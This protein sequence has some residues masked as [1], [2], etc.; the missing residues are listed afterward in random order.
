MDALPA[1]N[2]L[3]QFRLWMTCDCRLRK[4][5]TS[6]RACRLDQ[7]AAAGLNA[8]PPA[9]R[10]ELYGAAVITFTASGPR[11]SVSGLAVY[12]DNWAVIELAKHDLT[13][14][15]R[16]VDAVCTGDVDLLF[17]VTNAA[18]LIGPQGESRDAVRAFLDKIGPHWFP[19]LLSAIDAIARETQGDAPAKSCVADKFFLSYWAHRVRGYTP[20]SGKIIDMSEIFRLGAMLDWLGPQR[21]SIREGSAELGDALANMIRRHRADSEANPRWLDQHFPRLQF[22]P[23]KPAMFTYVNLV[24]TLITEAKSHQL[25]SH[26]GMDFCHAVI[27]SAFASFATLDTEWKRRIQTLPPHRLAFV[28]DPSQL[29]Q[30]VTDIELTL[31]RRGSLS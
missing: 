4:V 3:L 31:K 13:R 25:N 7:R 10:L 8:L 27:G 17:S 2:L 16:F 19:V 6:V 28:Y 14:R 12:L 23:S 22:N 15:Q 1:S 21:E 18:E 29:D 30:M 20:G 24:R 11:V 5:E 9:C 26:D